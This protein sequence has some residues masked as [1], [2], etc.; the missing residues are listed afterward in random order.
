[1]IKRNESEL[2]ANARVLKEKDA[3]ISGMGEQ[4][5]RIRECLTTKQQVSTELI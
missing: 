1:M 3:V 4:L 5:S 2:E